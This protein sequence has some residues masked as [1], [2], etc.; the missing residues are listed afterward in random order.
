LSACDARGGPDK[1]KLAVEMTLTELEGPVTRV[2][3]N[4]RLDAPGADRIGVRFTGAV[5][6]HGRNAIVDLSN[7]TFIA[8]L[9]LRLLISTARSLHLKG[10]RMILVGPSELVKEVLDEA[11]IDQIIPVVGTEAEALAELRN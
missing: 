11:A 4:G 10:G 7:V 5:A 3:L 1:E 6:A 8:S 9:G 2:S